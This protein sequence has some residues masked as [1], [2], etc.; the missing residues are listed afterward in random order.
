MP[1]SPWMQ[2]P[3]LAPQSEEK[4]YNWRDTKG[5]RAVEGVG[6]WFSKGFNRWR[7]SGGFTT[8]LMPEHFDPTTQPDWSRIAGQASL[9]VGAA[10]GLTAGALAA[11]PAVLPW[12]RSAMPSMTSRAGLQLG[13]TPLREGLKA[14]NPLDNKMRTLMGAGA[15]WLGWQNRPAWL[16]GGYQ[17]PKQDYFEH[18]YPAGPSL[19][20]YQPAPTDPDGGS[21]SPDG[22]YMPGGNVGGQP[23]EMTLEDGTRVWYNPLGGI[24]GTGDWERIAARPMPPAGLSASQQLAESQRQREAEM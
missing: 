23:T 21:T 9:G 8:P 19:A 7:G 12:L 22:L 3:A 2:E 10:A 15:G 14:I 13:Q 1:L 16:M 20:D 5:G 11:G 6:D 4:P 24:N 17:A 18:N